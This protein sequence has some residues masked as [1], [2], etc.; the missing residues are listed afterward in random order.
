M[1]KSPSST[2]NGAPSKKRRLT[3]D[4]FN[5]ILGVF[6]LVLAIVLPVAMPASDNRLNVLHYI[7]ISVCC[8]L[9]A[10]FTWRWLR[11]QLFQAF[12]N[13]VE[14]EVAETRARTFAQDAAAQP[15]VK[16]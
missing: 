1:A 5:G 9:S 3:L 16:S 6:F 8:L 12:R 14:E 7:G 2:V 4:P 11:A 13:E 15:P 10:F